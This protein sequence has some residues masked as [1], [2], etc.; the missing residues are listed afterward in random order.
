MFV[1]QTLHSCCITNRSCPVLKVYF[2]VVHPISESAYAALYPEDAI[3]SLGLKTQV[4]VRRCAMIQLGN[5]TLQLTNNDYDQYYH[6]TSDVRH[7]YL[8]KYIP[9]NAM[10]ALKRM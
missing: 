1:A 4:P 6:D 8:L 7:K 2:S 3:Q 5:N 9:Q 10:K